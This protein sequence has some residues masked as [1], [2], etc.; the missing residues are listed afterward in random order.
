[1]NKSSIPIRFKETLDVIQAEVWKLLL[2]LRQSLPCPLN[3]MVNLN[4][5]QLIQAIFVNHY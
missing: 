1:M 2:L 5:K 4:Y 3:S